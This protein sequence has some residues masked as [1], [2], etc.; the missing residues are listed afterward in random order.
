MP[1]RLRALD[2]LARR[3][4]GE[5]GALIAHHAGVSE[6]VVLTATR[7]YGPFPRPTQRLDA[8]SLPSEAQVD[9]RVRRWIRLRQHGQTA[10]AIARA[11]GISH[12]LVSRATRDHGPFPSDV[13]EQWVQARRAKRTVAHIAAENDVPQATI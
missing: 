3:H 4:A 11:E 1:E 6:A 7:P 13:V 2:W 5:S 8:R 9:E 12:Q 10:T